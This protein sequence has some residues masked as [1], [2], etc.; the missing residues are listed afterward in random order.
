MPPED[1]SFAE[2]VQRFAA[3]WGGVLGI[4]F[5]G[6]I[7][8]VL[9]RTLKLMPRTKPVQIAP[10]AAQEIAWA[11]IAGA[12]EAKAELRE[13]VD[14]LSDPKRF[15][16]LGAKVP[17]G[18]L[19]HG[20]PGTGKTLLAKAVAHESG[21]QFFSQSASSFV[22]MFA[23]LGAARI[24]RL[25]AEARKHSP[26]IV[27]IDELDAVGARRGSDHNSEREQTLNQLLVEMDGF[28]TGENVIVMA[29]SNLLE[30][31]DPALL[32]PGRFDRQVFVAPPDVRGR[33]RILGIHTRGKPLGADVDLDVVAAQTS[34]L[35]GADLANICNEAAIFCARRGGDRLAAADF[36]GA[37]ERVVAGVLSST[38]LNPRERE[39]VAYH[40]AGH[41]LCR[42]LLA[43][44]ERVHKISI[45]PRGS[46]LGYVM[47]LPDEDSYLKT[48]AELLDQIT[49]LLGGRVAEQV[50]FGAV[51]TGAAND[52]QRVAEV[53]HAMVHEY[54]MGS[55]S[56]TA[57]AMTDANVVSDATRRIRDEEQQ[58][59]IFEAERKARALVVGHR[60]A[61]ER[62]AR[63]LLE[64][65]VLERAQLDELLAAPGLRVVAASRHEGPGAAGAGGG[66]H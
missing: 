31:L 2:H 27:F 47:N 19:L 56:A 61:L 15:K 29:A 63:A 42:E 45:V 30:K 66:E 17:R 18:V 48:R 41:A 52:L 3:D 60:D 22:E 5:M 57:R 65:E 13:V 49:V 54:G 34:G 9:W 40:E 14:F 20:P 55:V 32:R 21:A 35:T 46:A 43:T 58:A 37:L 64:H 25:F 10:K 38:T 8:Y 24:R 7:A 26:A 4:V 59:I 23:G 39:V 36:D 33:R 53:A 11:D 51:T 16:A 44:T 6:V 50:V 12:D 62:I 28:A 1:L